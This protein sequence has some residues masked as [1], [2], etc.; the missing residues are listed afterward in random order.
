MLKEKARRFNMEKEKHMYS[1]TL[2]YMKNKPLKTV[3][4]Q[5]VGEFKRGVKDDVDDYLKSTEKFKRFKATKFLEDPQNKSKVEKE[6]RKG[7][8]GKHDQLNRKVRDN[9]KERKESSTKM[10]IDMRMMF[11][12]MRMILKPFWMIKGKEIQ[13]NQSIARSSIIKPKQQVKNENVLRSVMKSI[14]KNKSFLGKQ[15]KNTDDAPRTKKGAERV[16][17]TFEEEIPIQ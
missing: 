9:L 17:P 15:S 7:M 5:L 4:E 16:S 12:Y 6:A 1:L 14:G 11:M 13:K 3:H 8:Q 2:D 10:K